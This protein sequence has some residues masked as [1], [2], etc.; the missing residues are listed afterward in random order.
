VAAPARRGLTL[1]LWAAAGL[2]VF[3][4]LLAASV[5]I[6]AWLLNRTIGNVH[7]LDHQVC[8]LEHRLPSCIV[9]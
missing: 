5:S 9:P 8:M 3:F 1:P 4:A 6:N 2:L 7:R